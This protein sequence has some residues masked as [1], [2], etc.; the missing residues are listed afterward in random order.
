M[1]RAATRG[2]A[3][4]AQAGTHGPGAGLCSTGGPG[5]IRAAPSCRSLL[6]RMP[7]SA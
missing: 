6:C 3:V 1:L 4:A 2:L 5:V 7:P